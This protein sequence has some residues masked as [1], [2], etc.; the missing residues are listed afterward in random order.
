[1]PA[2][3]P[4]QPHRS[5]ATRRA[6]GA[7]AVVVLGI[8]AFSAIVGLIGTPWAGWSADLPQAPFISTKLHA[9][10]AA[11]WDEGH[12]RTTKRTKPHEVRKRKAEKIKVPETSKSGDVEILIDVDDFDG[13]VDDIDDANDERSDP[14]FCIAAASGDCDDADKSLSGSKRADALL[15][16]LG[17]FSF[18]YQS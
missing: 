8:A 9:E 12:V 18:W 13:T 17:L 15:F 4:S 1:M 14:P 10:G 7:A 2:P 6:A 3:R 5:P 11:T 16:L